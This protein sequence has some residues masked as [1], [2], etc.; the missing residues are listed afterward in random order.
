MQ[1]QPD[2]YLPV[3]RST[4]GRRQHCAWS[5]S[6]TSKTSIMV[7]DVSE[8]GKLGRPFRTGIDGRWCQV[9][10][11]DSEMNRQTLLGVPNLEQWL[12]GG[13]WA[14]ETERVKQRGERE[15]R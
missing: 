10:G 7:K 12:Q 1:G 2:S 9:G 15:E 5:S 13:T 11:R 4:R 14:R 6:S 8:S 3:T